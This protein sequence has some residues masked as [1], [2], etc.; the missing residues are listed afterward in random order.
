[1][2]RLVEWLLDL[3]HI[4]LGRDRPLQLNWVN[5]APAWLIFCCALAIIAWITLI[6]RREQGSAA[7][8][9]SLAMLRA[10]IVALVAAVIC[11]PVLVWQRNRIEQSYVVL[12]LDTSLSMSN[13]DVFRDPELE[14]AAAVGARFSD[15][16]EVHARSRIDLVK[17]SLLAEN[18]APLSALLARNAVQLS[19]FAAS[20]QTQG[21]FARNVPPDALSETL[22]GI[23]ADG[24]ATDLAGAIG[25]IIEKSQGRR[26]AGIVVAT[27]GQSTQPTNLKD[28]LDRARDRQ[29]PIYPLRIGSPVR[30]RDL[31]IA[32]VRA[33]ETVFLDDFISVEAE[34]AGHGITDST[35][36]TI[37]LVDERNKLVV[38]TESVTLEPESARTIV[39]LR[40]KPTVAG[41]ARYRVRAIPL[42]DERLTDNNFEHVDVTIVDEELRALFVDAYPR[43]EYRYLKNALSRESTVRFSVLLLEADDR[44]VQEGTDPI[45]RFPETPEELSRFDVVLFGDVDPRSGWLSD[46]QMKMLLDYVGNEGGGFG[47]IA[48][49]RAAPHRFLGTPLEK[50]I[51]VRIDPTFFGA[52][53]ST[54]VEGFA[55]LPTAE[56][57]QHRILRFMPD[58]ADNERLIQTL[59]QLYWYA[60]TEGPKPGASVLLEHPTSRTAYGAMPIVVLGRYGAG[61]LFFQATDDT[62]RWRRHTGELMHDTYWVRVA[63]ELMPEVGAARDRRFTLRTDRRR[64]A[65]GQAVQARVQMFDARLLAD[66]GEDVA[67]MVSYADGDSTDDIGDSGAVRVEGAGIVDRFTA[68]RLG[69]ESSQ[70]EGR[71]TAP[72]PGRYVLSAPD[73]PR[74]PGVRLGGVLFRVDPPNLE[75]QKPEADHET[76]ARIAESTGG[77]VL[78]LD[79]LA[80]GFEEIRDRSVQVPD[81]VSEPLWDSRLVLLLFVTMIS[82]E[83]VLRKMFGLL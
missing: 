69:P 34:L 63:R 27:D 22:E 72:K 32:S 3:E 2:N 41:P 49:E 42:P 50:L 56:G 57:N 23:A 35:P 39:E 83:W 29:I 81:D 4:E 82:M 33:E 75:S 11:Q 18:G 7:R 20:L 8:R 58:R 64:Y 14:R 73:L 52:Y 16:A 21:L 60:R 13:R 71:W 43:Y 62:W 76:L 55:P 40:A 19:T 36:V 17:R 68:V 1:M 37:E 44:F 67:L 38:A 45:R 61:R 47:L 77:R 54:L 26:L 53:E 51:P 24:E 65:Y 5:A 25:G 28:A 15:P 59:P 70:F 48:G 31:E 79:E 80:A 12:A 10:G 66:E 46:A 74:P 9:A 78:S 30:P 6:Y